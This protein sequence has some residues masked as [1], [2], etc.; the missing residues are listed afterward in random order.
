MPNTTASVIKE[1]GKTLEEFYG[2]I[3]GGGTTTGIAIAYDHEIQ[4]IYN[5]IINANKIL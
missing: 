5:D 3:F 2:L 1:K 4:E